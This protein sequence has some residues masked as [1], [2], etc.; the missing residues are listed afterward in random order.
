MPNNN[1]DGLTIF[2]VGSVII[3]LTLLINKLAKRKK[4]VSFDQVEKFIVI[5]ILFV[6]LI[7]AA[8]SFF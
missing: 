1:P 2:I 5:T 7:F 3:L 4:I 8:Y 6:A